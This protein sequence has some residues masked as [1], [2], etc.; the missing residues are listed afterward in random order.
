MFNA[1]K[2]LLQGS[3]GSR[4]VTE[5]LPDVAVAVCALLLEAAEA[6]SEFTDEERGLIEA[7]LCRSFGLNGEEV[8]ALIAETQRQ[9]AAAADLWPFTHAIRSR[10]TPEEKRELLVRVWQILLADKVL[11]AH[12]E[13]WARRLHEMLAVNH[14]LLFDAKRQARQLLAA[15][16]A[17]PA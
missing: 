14:S 5:K 2:S 6:D 16:A 13:Q 8:A 7:Q 10:Y 11:T 15:A 12:E 4:R 3:E 9:R 17:A 1:I